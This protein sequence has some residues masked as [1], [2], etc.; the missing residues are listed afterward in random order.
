MFSVGDTIIVTKKNSRAE[1][2]VG[3]VIVNYRVD[4]CLGI[5]FGEGF[6][7]HTLDGRIKTQTGYSLPYAWV[8]KIN[9]PLET[10]IQGKITP[11]VYE[12]VMQRV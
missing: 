6:S 1:N 4:K 11:D 2:L 8:Q 7:G 5:D 9:N 12:R 10:L 3:K